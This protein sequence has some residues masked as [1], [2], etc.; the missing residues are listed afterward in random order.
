MDIKVTCVMVVDWEES[1]GGP[2]LSDIEKLFELYNFLPNEGTG[3]VGSKNTHGEYSRV[4][5]KLFNFL[6]AGSVTNSFHDI[7]VLSEKK[8]EDALPFCPSVLGV[9][10]SAGARKDKKAIFYIRNDFLQSKEKFIS[11][12]ECLFCAHLGEFYGAVFE[13]SAA[14]GPA[15]YLSSLVALPNGLYSKPDT[16]YK[17]R[18]TRYRDNVNRSHYP[19]LGFFREIYSINYVTEAH[20]NKKFDG[21]DLKSFMEKNGNLEKTSF[22]PNVYRWS[23]PESNLN[24]VQDILEGSGIVLSSEC[25][26]TEV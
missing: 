7:R 15:S 8:Y 22:N 4:K 21:M 3:S 13:F 10:W 12:I 25:L 16:Q 26:I 14:L 2:L 18:I 5:K 1:I 19:R 17:E 11:D 23:I 24:K 20:L 9:A 6:E